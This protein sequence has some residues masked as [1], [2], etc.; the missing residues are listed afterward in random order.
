MSVYSK[1]LGLGRRI[2][3]V[4][5]PV[6]VWREDYRCP[7]C[8]YE[9]HFISDWSLT[10]VRANAKCPKCDCSERHRIQ[11]AVIDK[12]S[13]HYDFSQMS[14]LHMSPEPFNGT[15]LKALFKEYATA[16]YNGIGAD[17]AVDLTDCDLP[18]ASYDVIYAS[19]VFEHIPDDR[20]AAETVLRLLKPGGFAILPVPIVC[21]ETVE[22]PEMV[23]TEFGH[24]R[25]PG[26][27]YFDQFADL[28]DID[29]YSSADVDQSIQPWVYEDRSGYPSKWAPYR[30][31]SPGKRHTDIVPVLKRPS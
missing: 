14:I 19:H 7:L 3:N 18:D 10:G 5:V 28:F 9:G 17:M 23:M 11:W 12:L 29:T 24:I 15:Q 13:R 6:A 31:P 20:A 25:A 4:I 1:A 27:E 26:P 21:E 8:G 22:Y 30:T 16:E 2:D